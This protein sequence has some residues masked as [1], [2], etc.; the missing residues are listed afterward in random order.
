MK[1]AEKAAK[2]F[3]GA[4]S[5]SL[6]NAGKS[7]QE[8]GDK[9]SG[10]GKKLLPVSAVLTGAGAAAVKLAADAAD[11]AGATEQIFGGA[12]EK[13]KGWAEGLESYYGIASAE[14]LEY[15]NTMGA[16]LQNIGNLTEEEAATQTQTLIKLAGDL[17]AMYGGSTEDAV[18]ALTGSLKGNNTMLDNYGMAANDAMVK[19]KAMEMGLKAEGEELSLA[20]KQAATLALIMEQSGAAQ[21]QAAREADGASGSM[22]TLATDMKKSGCVSGGNF[23]A[24]DYS[25]RAG[26]IGLCN[27]AQLIRQWYKDSNCYHCGNCGGH[28]PTADNYWERHFSGRSDYCGL[29]GNGGGL[30]RFNRSNRAGDSGSSGGYSNRRITGKEL[31]RNSG[32]RQGFRRGN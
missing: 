24:R 31:G 25:Y 9:V 29:A 27:M 1:K 2:E 10:A 23:V 14:A 32:E 18:R 21:G 28:G 6:K 22:R 20:A 3:G 7:M 16:M 17:T 12:S 15:G 13:M 19:T 26:Y 8:F 4:L 30:R 11:A 5:Q